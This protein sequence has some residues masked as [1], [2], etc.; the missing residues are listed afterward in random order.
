MP[1]WPVPT[2]E[3]ATVALYVRTLDMEVAEFEALLDTAL[4]GERPDHPDLPAYLPLVLA[5]GM[6]L[7]QLA[8]RKT[9]LIDAP[10][11]P[12]AAV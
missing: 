8:D 1:E 5:P 3:A 10:E 12:A 11:P 6:R 9:V 7:H 4:R 2:W